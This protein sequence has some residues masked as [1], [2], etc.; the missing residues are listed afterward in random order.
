VSSPGSAAQL[1][2]ANEPAVNARQRFV[3]E[4]KLNRTFDT[5]QPRLPGDSGPAFAFAHEFE[6]SKSGSVLYT[7]GTTQELAVNYRT[8]RGNVELRPWWV[9]DSCYGGLNNMISKHYHAF[10]AAAEAA[11]RWTTQL[12]EG[13]ASYY[14]AERTADMEV[15][16]KVSGAVSD[17]SEEELYYAILALSARQIMA[18][19]VL[20]ESQPNGTEPTI[21]QKEISSDG[22]TNTVD[23][24]YP[25]LPFWLYANPELLRLLLAPVFDFQEAGMFHEQHAMHDIGRHYPNAI[26]YNKSRDQFNDPGGEE[27][28]PVEES[29]NMVI[30][31]YAYYQATNDTEYL[32]LHFTILT[33]WTQYL[34]DH[35]LYPVDQVTSGRSLSYIASSSSCSTTDTTQMTSTNVSQTTPT[36]QSKAS[37]P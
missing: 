13:V 27:A 37:S 35:C 34:A 7:V 20:T 33:Q 2:L 12:G 9:T 22:K 36:S 19:G 21:F 8:A 23:I 6:S 26:G 5:D 17:L 30:L 24:I 28:M 18:A 11:A 15:D 14:A 25:A 3:D 10:A 1:Y 29:A 4:G 31:A 16:E 32:K